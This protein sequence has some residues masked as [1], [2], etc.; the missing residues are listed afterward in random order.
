MFIYY[1]VVAMGRDRRPSRRNEAVGAMPDTYGYRSTRPEPGNRGLGAAPRGEACPARGARMDG[2][3]YLACIRYV[4]DFCTKQLVFVVG[5]F[6]CASKIC[7]RS[8]H[9]TI[10]TKIR[11]LLGLLSTPPSASDS[12]GLS[13]TLCALQIYLLTYLLNAIKLAF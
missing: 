8:T 1:L 10:V 4:L 5:E 13:L 2:Q 9:V 3:S 11:K 7:L 12:A 6:I